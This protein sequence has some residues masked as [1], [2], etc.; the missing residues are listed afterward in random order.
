MARIKTL[1][2]N[3]LIPLLAGIALTPKVANGQIVPDETL[4]EESST[5]RQDV[6]KDV[7]SDVIE[8]GATR[9]ANL[10]HSFED[11]NVEAGR[12]AYFANPDAI[13]N[14]LSRVTGSNSSQILGTLGVLGDANLFL[15]NPNG[16][17][18][19]ENAR[20][21]VGGSFF[22][23]TA[24]SLLFD[25][26]F[27][28]S[29]SN[30]EAPPLL[31]VNIPAGLGFRDDPGSIENQSVSEDVGLQVPTG[32][33]FALI[34]GDV[35][36]DGGKITAP[37][38]RVE[39]GGLTAAGTINLS[40]NGSLTFPDGV[41]RA[42]VSFSDDALVN[43]RAEGDGSIAI[44]TKNLEILQGS[45]LLAGIGFGL[46]SSNSQAED[47]IID[48]RA[49]IEIDNGFVFNNVEPEAIGNSGNIYIKAKSLF[50]SGGAQLGTLTVGQGDAGSVFV[51]ANESVSLT[52]CDTAIFSA[53][54][55]GAL[56]SEPL[57]PFFEGVG[58]SGD[59]TIESSSF[60]LTDGAQLVASTFGKQGN[61]GGVIVK[62]NES[63][64]LQGKGTAILSTVG[65]SN[66]TTISPSTVGNSGDIT[67]ESSSLSLTDGAQL[68][69]ST[70][71]RGNAG[72]VFVKADN[73]IYLVGED[74]AIFSTVG[75]PTSNFFSEDT[76]VEGNSGGI[77]LQSRNISLTS[78]PQ[79][80]TSTFGKGNAGNIFVQVS[81]A[82]S[83]E[84]GRTIVPEPTSARLTLGGIRN[85]AI[86]LAA[87]L[88][89]SGAST[90][91]FSTVESGATGNAGNIHIKSR[92]LSLTGG[93]EVQSLTR[94]E[95]NAGNIWITVKD[96]VDISGVAT[97]FTI[98]LSSL[99]GIKDTVGGFSSGLISST[100]EGSVGK[101][102]D[103][104]VTTSDLHLSNG[105]VL[106]ARTRSDN[107]GGDINV[108]VNT[109]E[110]IKGGQF[111][112]SSFRN[113]NAGNISIN[114]T[115]NITLSGSDLSFFDRL[116]QFGSEI[117]DND[118]P[119]SGL[120]AGAQAAGAAG[121]VELTAPTIL[122]KNSAQISASTF[123]MGRSG[124]IEVD[125]NVLAVTGGGQLLTTAFGQGNAGNINLNI[126]D[127]ISL[128]GSDPTYFDR[129]NQIAESGQEDPEFTIDPV[130][131]ESGIFANT[132]PDSTG[133]G[134]SVTV[135][136]G[137]LSLDDGAKFAVNSK[138]TGNGGS[139]KKL[140]ADNL[141]LNNNSEISATT[142]SGEG[143]NIELAISKDIFFKN[144]S[145]ISARAFGNANGGNIT[146]NAKDGS[147]V[148]FPN[149]NNDIIANAEQGNGG[150]INITAQGI[151]GLEERP[152]NPFTN[153]IDASSQFGLQGNF[154]L[155]TPEIDPSQGVVELPVNV[156]D[157]NK[158]IAQDACKQGIGSSL[159]V[160]GR[161]GLPPSS[162]Q[163]F[164]SNWVDVDLI[165][166]LPP[167]DRSSLESEPEANP[168]P[169]AASQNQL[170]P[171]EGWVRNEKGE[172]FLV[173]YKSGNADS[174]RQHNSDLCQPK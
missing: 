152:E 42:D 107:Q 41:T 137:K 117:I 124:N 61:A 115:D 52:G 122:I 45:S 128:S 171:A 68:V 53:V 31:T 82:V 22:A 56:V 37:G 58:N 3:V 59:I 114:A 147:I 140:S 87:D 78:G 51:Q 150:N 63:V 105:A 153:D 103:I 62:A 141:S 88:V 132:Q 60:S 47:I 84:G 131:P 167:E 54:K 12:G 4:G 25:N 55:S 6:I 134:G 89:E 126:S 165:Q 66:F 113:G 168:S 57:G 15:I 157:P 146:I 73:F 172:V 162:S 91:F 127:H 142:V 119:T 164:N 138:G 11:F 69:A 5:V 112:V 40:D 101:G 80:I 10:F 43:V 74:T 46:G 64:S 170:I 83:L 106:N 71:E 21:D 111:L 33:T 27:E 98:K 86:S 1:L 136:A 48:A 90:G 81:D 94:G 158:L 19:G 23:S 149:Q 85:S 28:F 173:A 108:N 38:G 161:G 93:A 34:G 32:E 174:Q 125:A 130:S 120:F 9:G 14:I 97:P 145:T 36:F 49:E 104:K 18:F 135:Q 24:D 65:F 123:G 95:G 13:D 116:D 20:L 139:I 129:F 35:S 39:L 77:A 92:S 96:A 2:P 72:S 76:F 102:G 133:N 29:G 30:P 143:G 17:V 166:P 67:I 44:N 156:Q 99:N 159:V 8:G 121:K 118:G 154:S 163:S 169:D 79:I 7:D 151:F 70:F 155:N 75:A 26:G 109:L 100:E 16:I 160:T 110:V 50:L 148:A 144:N